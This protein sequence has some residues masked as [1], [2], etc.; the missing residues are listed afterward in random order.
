MKTLDWYFDFISPFSYLQ[1]EQLDHLARHATLRLKPV[2]F[3][4]LLKHWGNV[5]P[6]ELPTKRIWTF[7]H[8]A[9]LAHRH[10]IVLKA[11]PEHP[12]NPLPLL[13]LAIALECRPEAVHRLFRY[14][15]QDGHLPSQAG[16][17]QALLAELGVS[18]P[19]CM[20]APSVKETLRRNGEEAIAAGVFGV[21]TSVV[22]GRLFW[23]FD[24]KEMVVAYLL[25]DPFFDSE[26]LRAARSLPEGVQRRR[27]P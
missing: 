15:W 5:G 10:G 14:V 26:T 18:D 24:A 4:G 9:W 8:C 22:D 27:S 23:G 20:E 6:A 25:G 1:S 2:L 13:R 21:P 7:E 3:A 19:A 16:P 12:F 17:W 11:P